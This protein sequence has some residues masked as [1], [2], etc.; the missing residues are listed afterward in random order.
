MKSAPNKHPEQPPPGL[1]GAILDQAPYGIVVCRAD[2]EITFANNLATFLLQCQAIGNNLHTIISK[3][4][5]QKNFAKNWQEL[6]QNKRYTITLQFSLPESQHDNRN[7]QLSL[8]LTTLR[9]EFFDASIH[10]LAFIEDLSCKETLLLTDQHYTDSLEQLV[11]ETSKE[12]EEI[13]KQLIKS[14]KKAAMTETAGAIAHELRQPL[15]AVLGAIELINTV[16]R[17]S[18]AD[19][20]LDKLLAT[21]R[22]QC[23]RVADIIKKMEQLVVYKTRPYIKGQKILDLDE[24]SQKQNHQD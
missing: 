6:L 7:S 2:G 24:S 11:N 15:T 17:E 12:L 8:H 19:G 5:G 14:E 21:I 3:N 10:V 18:A 1:C 23:L 22:K 20:H 4:T 16:P 9:G 13:Q